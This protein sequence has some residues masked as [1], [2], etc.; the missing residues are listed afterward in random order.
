MDTKFLA[1]NPKTAIVLHENKSQ[2][3]LYEFTIS[4]RKWKERQKRSL[5]V[6]GP[7]HGEMRTRWEMESGKYPTFYKPYKASGPDYEYPMIWAFVGT[8]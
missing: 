3:V 8:E 1:K 7:M 6:G 5:C 2:G 4:A